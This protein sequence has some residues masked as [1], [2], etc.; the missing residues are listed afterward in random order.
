MKSKISMLIFPKKRQQPASALPSGLP[1]YIQVIISEHSR[2]NY[3]ESSLRQRRSRRSRTK[4]GRF[5]ISSKFCL[6][7]CTVSMQSSQQACRFRHKLLPELY[8]SI[9]FLSYRLCSCR[10][11]LSSLR[12]ICRML[13]S[14]WS[15]RSGTSR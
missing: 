13:L 2:G 3:I 1:S 10:K 7:I 12:L 6:R 15:D 14:S 9:S 4:I 8:R 11:Q 5:V